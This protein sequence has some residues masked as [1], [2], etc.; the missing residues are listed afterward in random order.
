MRF[1]ITLLI[2]SLGIVSLARAQT[3]GSGLSLP[4]FISLRADRVNMRIGPG[5][6]YPIEWLYRR[7]S[8]PV[9]VIAEYKNWRKIRDWQGTQGWIHQSMLS[10]HR[11]II[12]TGKVR[13]IRNRQ[14]SRSSPVAS[15]EPGVVGSLLTCPQKGNW[16]R[17]EIKG[18]KGWLRRTH[19]WGVYKG[20][21]IE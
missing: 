14:S 5:G 7:R 9:E 17:I 15:V 1:F 2:C 19:F 21:T 16:C 11:T 4:R 6:Q 8:L 13:I 12:V 18:F 10:R 20:E 3:N